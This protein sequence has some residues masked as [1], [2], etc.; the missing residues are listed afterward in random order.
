MLPGF[1]YNKVVVFAK[2]KLSQFV[3]Y[4]K[5][6]KGDVVQANKKDE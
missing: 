1:V 4:S 3:D 2:E 5:E 6:Q